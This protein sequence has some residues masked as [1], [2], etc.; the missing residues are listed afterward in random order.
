MCPSSFRRVSR[1]AKTDEN[2]LGFALLAAIGRAARV[3]ENNWIGSKGIGGVWCRIERVR[4]MVN[5]VGG[6]LWKQNMRKTIMKRS[7]R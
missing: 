4:G 6:L 5:I 1:W 7:I 2:G 3:G